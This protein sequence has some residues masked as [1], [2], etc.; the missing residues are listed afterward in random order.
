MNIRLLI[1]KVSKVN[2]PVHMSTDIIDAKHPSENTS[3][4]WEKRSRPGVRCAYSRKSTRTVQQD[5]LTY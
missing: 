1:L 4:M 3:I 2:Y 5:P